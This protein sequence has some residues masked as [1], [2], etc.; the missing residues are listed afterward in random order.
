MLR[1]SRLKP[2]S[3]KKAALKKEYLAEKTARMNRQREQ[4]GGTFCERCDKL[5]WVDGHHPYG[6][7]GKWILI[8]FLICRKC[9]DWIH[10]NGKAA[11]EEGWTKDIP[12]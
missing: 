2:V 4:R 3:A 1:R 8:F 12:R 9:H 7:A 5:R 10:A 6:Q 11:R